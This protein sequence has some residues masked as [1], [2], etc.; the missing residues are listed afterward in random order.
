MELLSELTPQAVLDSVTDGVY[1][2]DTSRKIVYWNDAAE[3]ITG[4]PATSGP[5]LPARLT[6]IGRLHSS[7]QASGLRVGQR[8]RFWASIAMTT[9][10]AT[11][12]RTGIAS[13]G[14]SIVRYTA[15]S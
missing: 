1:V 9:C 13:V 15:R 5:V 7:V 2:T 3:R 12:T 10:C 11:W 6:R 14:R 8:A 4:W